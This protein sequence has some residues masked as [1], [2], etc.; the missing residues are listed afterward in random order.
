MQELQRVL[1]YEVPVDICTFK[2]YCF[3]ASYFSGYVSLLKSINIPCLHFKLK[4]KIDVITFSYFIR[5]P[6]TIIL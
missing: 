5:S 6:T 1:R 2:K 4:I 3:I